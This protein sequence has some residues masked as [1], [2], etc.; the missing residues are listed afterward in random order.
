MKVAFCGNIVN[1]FYQMVK[2]LREQSSIDAHLYIDVQ[3]PMGT[4]PESDTPSLKNHYPHWIHQGSYLNRTSIL[5]PWRSELIKELNQYD[6][7]M[8]SYLG[9]MFSQFIQRPAIFFTTGEGGMVVTSNPEIWE[10]LEHYDNPELDAGEFALIFHL[11]NILSAIGLSQLR[12][13]EASLVTR[14]QIAE[15]YQEGLGG[16]GCVLPK[17]WILDH[18]STSLRYCVM[19]REA[20]VLRRY[21]RLLLQ[22]ELLC[23]APLSACCTAFV[24]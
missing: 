21:V 16:L 15:T 24:V 3:D 23:D 13:F 5:F 1:I 22:K 9:P 2:A 7:V 4:R 14:Q 20:T 11:S 8:I 10:R 17:Q 18:T 6:V 19:I 12:H